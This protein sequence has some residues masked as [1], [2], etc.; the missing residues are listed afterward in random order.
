MNSKR[1]DRG[2][3][4]VGVAN[5]TVQL[6]GSHQLY[7]RVHTQYSPSIVIGETAFVYVIPSVIHFCGYVTAIYMFRVADN[8][9]LQNLVERV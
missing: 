8:E 9:H 7:K 6:T 3:I 2:T 5:R 4:D 1:R